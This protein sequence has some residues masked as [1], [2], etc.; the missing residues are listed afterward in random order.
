MNL[1]YTFDLIPGINRW[2]RYYEYLSGIFSAPVTEKTDKYTFLVFF[3][4]PQKSGYFVIENFS[5][6]G[7]STGQMILNSFPNLL[8]TEYKL[9]IGTKLKA[10][11]LKS[12]KWITEKDTIPEQ[13]DVD[14]S[15]II[16]IEESAVDIFGN[17]PKSIAGAGKQIL[18]NWES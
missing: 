6:T 11:Y 14:K 8:S 1:K 7:G 4:N 2:E 15:Q 16:L 5:L 12:G 18:E 13:T 9:N 3:D 10:I 17:D